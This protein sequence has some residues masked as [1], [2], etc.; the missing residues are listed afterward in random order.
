[1]I[2]SITIENDIT[3]IINTHDM[4]S[5]MEIGANIALLYNGELAWQG[6]KDEATR[7][8]D[9]MVEA[10]P[11]DSRAESLRDSIKSGNLKL[12]LYSKKSP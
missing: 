1:M 11:T 8:L 6:N 7:I 10:D 5:V 2:K 12:D 9:G 3:T 4:N